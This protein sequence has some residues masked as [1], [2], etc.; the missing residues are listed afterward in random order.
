MPR[1]R[2]RASSYVRR[3]KAKLPLKKCRDEYGSATK[4]QCKSRRSHCTWNKSTGCVK[5]P[6][7]SH[8]RVFAKKSTPRR[9]RST[10]RRTRRR[11]VS[12]RPATRRSRT[13]TRRRS[14][15]AGY[16][17]YNSLDASYEWDPEFNH[18][19][20]NFE[21]CADRTKADCLQY[22]NMCTYKRGVGCGRNAYLK[23][24]TYD[25]LLGQPDVTAAYTALDPT[26]PAWYNKLRNRYIPGTPLP[27]GTPGGAAT[28]GTPG[29]TGT[30]GRTYTSHFREYPSTPD[31]PAK[32]VKISETREGD[33]VV[34]SREEEV[35]EEPGEEILFP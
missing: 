2:S 3:S 9:R 7:K 28:P 14:P 1:S 27:S 31:R 10:S 24:G 13:Y 21:F 26:F 6:K 32:I 35:G 23:Q 29:T 4:K 34:E 20:V 30:P 12:R 19:G 5:L 8:S 15:G 18:G 11:S 22:P 16:G 17:P 25:E 33:R